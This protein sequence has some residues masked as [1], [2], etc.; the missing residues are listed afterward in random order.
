MGERMPC[1]PLSKEDRIS[2]V[3]YRSGI[4]LIT[5]VMVVFSYMFFNLSGSR[6][7]PAISLKFDFLILALYFATGLSVFFIHL[8]VSRFHRALKKLYYLSVAALVVLIL[9]GR[10]NALGVLIY[11]H[12]G[13]LLLL[14]V[15]G[16][17]GFITAKE[18]FC[19]RL[20]EGYIIALILP[21]YLLFFAAGGM[22]A[23]GA[24]YGLTIITGLL[25]LFTFRKV[26]QPMHYDIG[27]KS[28]YS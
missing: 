28:A 14:P 23:R 3:L 19:F 26:F 5:A 10:G 20:L 24:L 13:P 25:V 4:V 7:D 15:S 18:A 17:I 1:Q 16:C 27:D 21:L 9:L 11:K 22:S 6:S 8:Y 12:Y 2:V